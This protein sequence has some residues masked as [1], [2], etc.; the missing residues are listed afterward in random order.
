[1]ENREWNEEGLVNWLIWTGQK[2]FWDFEEKTDNAFYKVQE[3]FDPLPRKSE[4]EST[5]NYIYRLKKN[6][7]LRYLAYQIR[8]YNRIY[9]QAYEVST[10]ELNHESDRK[11]I[12]FLDQVE[13]YRKEYTNLYLETVVRQN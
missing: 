3:F 7:A 2:L 1:M 10:Y 12:L 4:G 6:H 13:T 5:R 11:M 9:R 8:N